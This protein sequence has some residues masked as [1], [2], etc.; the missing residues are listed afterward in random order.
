MFILILFPSPVT[1]SWRLFCV[2]AMADSDTPVV[3]TRVGQGSG[4]FS[5]Q[6][7][8]S[9][10]VAQGFWKQDSVLLSHRPWFLFLVI[11]STASWQEFLNLSSDFI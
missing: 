6:F 11:L 5:E 4:S 1:A 3:G 9:Y 10:F 8:S 2:L 7:S